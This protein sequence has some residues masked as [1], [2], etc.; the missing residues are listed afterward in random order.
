MDKWRWCACCSMP[1]RTRTDTI[2]METTPTR[3]RYIKL[4]GRAMKRWFGFWSNV[5]RDWTSRTPSTRAHHS[6]GPN[7]GAA[8]RSRNTSVGTAIG[9]NDARTTTHDERVA[10]AHD[11][12]LATLAF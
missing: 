9:L 1:A 8:R 5:E 2:P 6:V 3:R 10:T 11:E 12:R 7:T 4:F